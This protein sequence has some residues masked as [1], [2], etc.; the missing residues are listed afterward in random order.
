MPESSFDEL[1]ATF[2]EIRRF[3]SE[4]RKTV[5]PKSRASITITGGE[6]M[7]HPRFFD[8]LRLIRSK[9][10]PIAVLSNG[11]FV[12]RSAAKELKRLDVQFVQISIEGTRETH[13]AI[14]GRG[15]YAKAYEALANL[16]IEDVPA[17]VS[18][19][20]HK[21]NSGEFF[22]VAKDA[23]KIGV[24]RVWSDRLIPLGQGAEISGLL[25]SPSDT[26]R[27]VQHMSDT[28]SK[29]K[30]TRTEIA[31]HRAL[32]F[33][34]CGGNPYFCKAGWSLLTL[35]PGGELV[36]CRR[37]P[38]PS[39][40]FLRKGLWELYHS[41]PILQNLRNQDNLNA[42]CRQCFYTKLCRGGLKCLAYA[43]TGDP[44]SGDPGCWMRKDASFNGDD[45]HNGCLQ[46]A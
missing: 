12:D 16:M 30:R 19:T 6:P 40:N 25:M 32:Q 39:G 10:L 36:P 11:H 17:F 45:S 24:E 23:S 43:L 15:S 33:A 14:R 22:Q 4:H 28:K 41:S 38:I 2:A 1:E 5:G 35:L 8:L 20:A 18:F 9:N 26:R 27:F 46:S 29:L 42:S 34:G 3:M 44:W 7:I 37:M 31:M 13:D 21:Q